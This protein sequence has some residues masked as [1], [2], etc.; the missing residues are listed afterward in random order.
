MNRR[1]FCLFKV[2]FLLVE[3]FWR[4]LPNRL[5]SQ[6]VS[7]AERGGE[8]AIYWLGIT[9]TNRKGFMLS[10]HSYLRRERT[11]GPGQELLCS[12]KKKAD[13]TELDQLIVFTVESRQ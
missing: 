2:I 3:C 5:I 11:W 10:I 6:A 13:T 9:A 1:W 8:E 12:R 7:N 4:M